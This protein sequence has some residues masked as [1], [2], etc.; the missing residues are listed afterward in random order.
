MIHELE[1]VLYFFL[2]PVCTLQMPRKKVCRRKVSKRCGRTCISKKYKCRKKARA[3]PIPAG[4]TVYCGAAGGKFYVNTSKRTGRKYKVY[5]ARRAS[6][7]V[8]GKVARR[9]PIRRAP[10]IGPFGPRAKPRARPTLQLK[11]KPR[12][13]PQPRPRAKPQPIPRAKPRARPTLQLIAKPR[14]KPQP[15]PRAKPQPIPRAKPPARP[16]WETDLSDCRE[17]MCDEKIY[18]HRGWR[19][20]GL[21][22]HPDKG[23]STSRFQKAANCNEEGIYCPS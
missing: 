11:A 23:G 13:K 6:C 17:F 12:A 15:G 3:P 7:P 20:A 14:A 16:D 1:S 9:R 22:L 18:D 8:G 4:K 5:V 10:G 19:K 21:R 2:V